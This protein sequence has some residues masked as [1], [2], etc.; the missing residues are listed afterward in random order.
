MKIYI[1]LDDRQRPNICKLTK[2]R[3]PHE[4]SLRWYQASPRNTTRVRCFAVRRTVRIEPR[5]CHAGTDPRQF[6]ALRWSL[7]NCP[8]EKTI[9]GRIIAL[10]GMV[11]AV[12]GSSP[13]RPLRCVLPSAESKFFVAAAL[14]LALIDPLEDAKF[15]NVSLSSTRGWHIF[16]DMSS[17]PAK[18]WAYFVDVSFNVPVYAC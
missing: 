15:S 14:L 9:Y 6:Y 3:L 8:C 5:D 12:I 10:N 4:S 2:K 18:I 16:N 1:A 7:L 11:F 17:D 13:G